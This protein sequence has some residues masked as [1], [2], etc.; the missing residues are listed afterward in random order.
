MN[1]SVNVFWVVLFQAIL[2]ASI[3]YLIYYA[4]VSSWP[5]AKLLAWAEAQSSTWQVT[6]FLPR[7]FFKLGQCPA[8]AGFWLGWILSWWTL[9]TAQLDLRLAVGGLAVFSTPVLW[10]LLSRSLLAQQKLNQSYEPEEEPLITVYQ[11]TCNQGHSWEIVG[12]YSPAARCPDCGLAQ[13]GLPGRVV[14]PAK[15]S[16]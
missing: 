10:W 7:L 5:R 9:P 1:N 3:Y 12:E 15:A 13:S 6:S 4:E 8:C 16:V 11:A 2:P 14:R